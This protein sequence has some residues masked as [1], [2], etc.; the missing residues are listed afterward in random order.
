MARRLRKPAAMSSRNP[1][2]VSNTRKLLR[3]TVLA[4]ALM[5]ILAVVYG[6]A[7]A[8]IGWIRAPALVGLDARMS[9]RDLLTAHPDRNRERVARIERYLAGRCQ[10]RG[11][12]DV[13][14]VDCASGETP[15][16]R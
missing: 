15:V 11:W 10:P 6:L 3:R 7:R 12:L 8:A 2:A 16:K 9:K 4:A 14:Y 5:I 1:L 13:Y